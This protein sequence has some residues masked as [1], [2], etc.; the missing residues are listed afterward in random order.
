[1]EDRPSPSELVATGHSTL[2][3][4]HAPVPPA[5]GRSAA[6]WT[7]VLA[8]Q[9]APRHLLV[10]LVPALHLHDFHE[11]FHQHKARMKVRWSHWNCSPPRRRSRSRRPPPG[12]GANRPATGVASEAP[13]SAFPT[14]KL[15]AGA[16]TRSEKR[17]FCGTRTCSLQLVWSS[18]R[19]AHARCTWTD[20]GPPEGKRG[21]RPPR[22]PNLPR[23]RRLS[24]VQTG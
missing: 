24:H 16:R 2:R 14:W 20:R 17:T 7:A 13:T 8:E 19:T 1:M 18:V 10:D 3:C 22:S 9:A 6:G 11:D 12:P 15:S 4:G 5:T 23:R 21:A